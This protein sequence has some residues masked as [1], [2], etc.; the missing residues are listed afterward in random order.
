MAYDRS[1]LSPREKRMVGHVDQVQQPYPGQQPETPEERAARINRN[2]NELKKARIAALKGRNTKGVAI[3]DAELESGRGVDFPADAEYEDADLG[4]EVV[5]DSDADLGAEVQRGVKPAG[6]RPSQSTVRHAEPPMSLIE[7]E[8]KERAFEG[9]RREFIASGK[10]LKPGQTVNQAVAE[11]SGI[12]DPNAVTPGPLFTGGPGPRVQAEA[13]QAADGGELVYGNSLAYEAAKPL[14]AI[15]GFAA[16]GPLGATAAEGVVRATA[17]GYNLNAALDRGMEPERAAEIFANELVKGVGVDALFNFGAPLVGQILGKIPGLN[18]IADK[19]HAA[20]QRRLPGVAPRPEL[21]DAKITKLQKMTDDPARKK[22]VEKLAGHVEGDY[23]P[24]KGQVKGKIGVEERVVSKAF[25][26]QFEEQEAA[27]RAG[28]DS[29]RKELVQPG[30]QPTTQKLGQQITRLADET[31]DATKRR[32][33]PVFEAANRANVVVDFNDVSAVARN[34]LAKDAEV[35][36]SGKLTETERKHLA[37][38][39]EDVGFQPWRSAEP[40]L[41]FISVQKEKL[42]SL[43]PDGKPTEYFSKVVGDLTRTADSAFDEAARRMGNTALADA[44]DVARREY[45]Q[46]MEVV[47]TGS[48]KQALRKGDHAPEDIGRMLWQK[49]KV[50]RINELDDLIALAKKEGVASGEALN[51]LRR[52][53]TRGFLQDAVQDV[54]SAAN[55]SKNLADPAHRQTWEV[56]TS[57]PGGKELKDAMAVLEN[58]AQMATLRDTSKQSPFLGIG[59]SRAAGGGLGISWVTGAFNPWLIGGGMSIA[60]LMRLM[61]T[62]Y[63]HGDKGVLNTLSKVIRANSTATAASTKALQALVP[64]LEKAAEKYKVTD[65]FLPKEEQSE[66]GQ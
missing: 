27:L 25:P 56:L 63:V 59:L 32:L 14:A 20:I 65:L 18:R 6:P 9:A 10:P 13:Q 34:A 3:L 50:T 4:T 46:T 48:I 58:A 61:S 23:L 60:G 19:I 36:G 66:E 42:R 39:V 40:A 1:N 33:R 43:N 30:S 49:G 15:G 64:Q 11:H 35:V 53:V 24:T 45:K 12:P 62:A 44:L 8:A 54:E 2:W 29:M 41:D 21:Y 57:G 37:K 28:A 16:Y 31:V 38:I 51:K 17:L 55:W 5:M 26:K 22:A 7:H 52:N 47:Y